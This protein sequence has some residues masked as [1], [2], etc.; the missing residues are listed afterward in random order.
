MV[1]TSVPKDL[2]GRISSFENRFQTMADRIMEEVSWKQYFLIICLEQCSI[3]PTL[4]DLAELAGS[5][6]QNVKQLLIKLERKGFV[7]IYSDE[8]DKRKQ[9]I[10][11]T[12]KCRTFC[13]TNNRKT[14]EVIDRMFCGITEEQLITTIQTISA[15][16]KNMIA[17]NGNEI[18]GQNP[19]GQN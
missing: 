18:P 8:K 13:E 3:D 10:R 11:L 5:S 7:E 17:E 15:I 14:A 19:N 6:H 2:L 4:N 1:K 9:R 12:E 16:E